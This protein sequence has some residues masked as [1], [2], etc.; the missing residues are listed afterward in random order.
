MNRPYLRTIGRE[1]DFQLTGT[2]N[3]FQKLIDIFLNKR[4][5]TPIKA[6]EENRK[7]NR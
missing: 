7:P 1:E 6:Q 3:G 5:D 4:K 2:E